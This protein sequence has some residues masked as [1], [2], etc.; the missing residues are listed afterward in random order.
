MDTQSTHLSERVFEASE[1][2]LELIADLSDDQLRVPYLPTINPLL[3]E[4]CHLAYFHEYWVLRQGAG[5]DPHRPDVDALFD[6]MTVGHETRWRLPV[7]ERENA[8]SYVRAVRDRVLD[9]LERG[10]DDRQLLYYIRYSVMHEDMHAEALTYTRQALG[11]SYP[12]LGVES[13]V[14]LS[15]EDASGDVHLRGGSFE[16]GADPDTS[17]CF[18]NEKWAHPVRVSP[19]AISKT[20]VSEG[21]FEGFIEDAGYRRQELW[22]SEGW[23]WR[24]ASQA[25]LPLYW[26][27]AA[28]G[29]F[30]RRHF[31]QWIPIESA[32]A[33]IHVNWYE[34]DAFCRWAG[35]RLPTEVEWEMAAAT[36][37]GQSLANANLD[38]RGSGPVDV[39]ACSAVDSAVGCRQMIGNVWE[40]TDTT[41]APFPGFVPDMYVDYSQTS[42][43]TR[44]VLRGGCWATRSRMVRDTLRN[45]YQPCRRDVFSGFRTCARGS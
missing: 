40:W 41:F 26:R 32:R 3:W 39:A 13:G 18:D 29:G 21:E 17:F 28:S 1:R 7:P 22:S 27:R 31:D 35:R 4:F 30:E 12:T 2:S 14:E 44:K 19:F 45:F 24:L 36:S 11:Y 9:L 34:A 16:L 5:Q 43:H 6:S 20:A 42:F 10:A 8:L 15:E 33:V 25:E 37:T 38:W 23:R